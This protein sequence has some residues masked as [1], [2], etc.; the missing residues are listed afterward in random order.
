MPG[1]VGSSIVTKDKDGEPCRLGLNA[2]GRKSL[3]DY[4][5]KVSCTEKLIDDVIKY[6]NNQPSSQKQLTHQLFSMG[7]KKTYV[8]GF[9]SCENPCNMDPLGFIQ[10]VLDR[11]PRQAKH[12][13][14]NMME[15]HSI[16]VAS[17]MVPHV[18]YF[19]WC[20]MQN[21]AL[22]SRRTPPE[23]PS[24]KPGWTCGWKNCICHVG[25]VPQ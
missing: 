22:P 13:N 1:V 4:F 25:K 2:Q 14:L 7:K 9:P 18:M 24:W 10:V 23:M 8:E 21:D 19:F 12:F 5:S 3:D 20:G 17:Q 6:Y 11:V 16:Q 15:T